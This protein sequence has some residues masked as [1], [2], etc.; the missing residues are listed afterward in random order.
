MSKGA[1]AVNVVAAIVLSDEYCLGVLAC[2]AL[3]SCTIA[4]IDSC[5][6]AKYGDGEGECC[7]CGLWLDG[8]Q[9]VRQTT[10]QSG[11]NDFDVCG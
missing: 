9:W 4:T 10:Q 8:S 7:I 2:S 1:K 6:F 5:V 3:V 11:A